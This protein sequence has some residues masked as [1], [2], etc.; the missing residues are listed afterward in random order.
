[1]V[2]KI[3][4][5]ESLGVKTAWSWK[6][7]CCSRL[8]VCT[9]I[10]DNYPTSIGPVLFICF[11][12]SRFL[13]LIAENQFVVV[14]FMNCVGS[15]CSIKSAIDFLNLLRNSN[16]RIESFICCFLVISTLKSNLGLRIWSYEI[17]MRQKVRYLLVS[18][19]LFGLVPNIGLPNHALIKSSATIS[20][21]Q[22]NSWLF[23][24]LLRN[25]IHLR[26]QT[27][28]AFSLP[29]FQKLLRT[30]V[31]ACSRKY[32]SWLHAVNRS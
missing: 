18:W 8:I 11:V 20:L 1:V 17:R 14:L 25:F 24:G 29:T 21:V 23:I 32:F 4:T 3:V 5:L 15:Q 31:Q 9:N 16:A 26:L 12:R 7:R 28:N 27:G 10:C 19:A 30:S 6:H 13:S 2:L 22:S